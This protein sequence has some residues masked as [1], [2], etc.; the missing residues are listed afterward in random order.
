M[1]ETIL[2]NSMIDIEMISMSIFLSQKQAR[3]YDK[4]EDISFFHFSP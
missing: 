4:G 1:V 3:C 2:I